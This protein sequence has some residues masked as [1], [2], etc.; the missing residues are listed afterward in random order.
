LKRTIRPLLFLAA[1]VAT[2]PAL[3]VTIEKT[4]I[5]SGDVD[6]PVE[7]AIPGGKGPFP[8][9]LFRNGCNAG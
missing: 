7:F 8:P 5:R 9:V 6:V 1:S 3:G 4:S 2:F